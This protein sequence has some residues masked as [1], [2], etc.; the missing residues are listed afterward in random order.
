MA[1]ERKSRLPRFA[2]NDGRT[3]TVKNEVMWQK[4]EQERKSKE[5]IAALRSQ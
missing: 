4:K 2:R 1:T 5:Q 3:V